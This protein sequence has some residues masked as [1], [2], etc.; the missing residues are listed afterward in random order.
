MSVAAAGEFLI[1]PILKEIWKAYRQSLLLWSH[2]SLTAEEE[3]DE[4]PG[5]LFTKRTA[6]GMVRDKPYLMVVTE[7][8]DDDNAAWGQC[9]AALLTAQTI[10]ENERLVLY[11]LATDGVGWQFG[12]LQGKSIVREPRLFTINDLPN[13]FA[14]LHYI[15]EQAKEQAALS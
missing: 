9:L 6:L 13:L 12:K 4:F 8:R 14:A 5:Y 3:L 1:A 11:G 10:N 7:K 15:F 2:V